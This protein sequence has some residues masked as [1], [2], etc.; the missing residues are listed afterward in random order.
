MS[1]TAQLII[2]TQFVLRRSTN[3]F[4]MSLVC[5]PAKAMAILRDCSID[6]DSR[7]WQQTNHMLQ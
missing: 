7:V 6:A 2:R 1:A 5:K 3:V 4:V